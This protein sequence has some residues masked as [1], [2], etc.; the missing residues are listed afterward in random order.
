MPPV[1][2]EAHEAFAD[3][4]KPSKHQAT[5]EVE[6][7]VVRSA[8]GVVCNSQATA[9]RLLTLYGPIERLLVLPNGVTPLTDLPQ[10]PWGD[11][12]RHIVYAGSFFGWK[13]VAD[14]VAAAAELKGFHIIL[15]GG[16]PEQIERLRAVLPTTGASIEILPRLP[17]TE[18][19]ARIAAGCIAVLPNRPDPDSTF[20]SPI[21]LFEY[22]ASGCAV[23]ASEL[24]S[25][26]EI[27]GPDE[28]V[29]FEAGNPAS[30]AAALKAI[31]SDC[32][33][34]KTMGERLREKS[35]GYTWEGR[36]RKLKAFVEEIVAEK[37]VPQ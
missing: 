12:H 24:P 35:A 26:R 29:W 2:Y 10:K 34:A 19:M 17:H 22:M 31:G 36:A 7:A 30:L 8:A 27:L 14:L 37:S 11:C 4:A 28:A 5:A 21:K 13:G 16:E 32:A 33:R 20:T 9:D 18:V 1:V 3:T 23:V 6:A 15:I 25:I